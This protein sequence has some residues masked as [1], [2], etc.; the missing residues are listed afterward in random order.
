MDL[1]TTVQCECYGGHTVMVLEAFSQYLFR[2]DMTSTS[3]ERKI[4]YNKSSF[5]L[6][7]SSSNGIRFTASPNGNTHSNFYVQPPPP[8]SD[9]ECSFF[10]HQCLNRSPLTNGTWLSFV[11]LPILLQCLLLER[12]FV[13]HNHTTNLYIPYQLQDI[14]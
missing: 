9:I 12:V 6:V 10:S 3:F 4:Q 5:I 8:L 1:Q 11:L 14:K 2:D 7:K 13:I